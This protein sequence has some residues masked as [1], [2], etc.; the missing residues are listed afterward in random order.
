LPLIRFN[1]HAEIHKH[2]DDIPEPVVAF[3]RNAPHQSFQEEITKL[4]EGLIQ[5]NGDTPARNYFKWLFLGLCHY[6]LGRK[7]YVAY[8]E[9]AEEAAF[10]PAFL[11]LIVKLKYE[12]KRA[13]RI[14]VV[15]ALDEHLNRHIQKLER[16]HPHLK[17]VIAG[18]GF[19]ISDLL[20]TWNKY[21][22]VFLLGHGEDKSEGY[23]GH[24]TLGDQVMT[25]SMLKEHIRSNPLH[26]K[27]MGI[28]CCGMA[29][30]DP[31]IKSHF[32]FFIMDMESSV[33]IF[34]E[35]F[36]NGYLLEYYR[37][38]NVIDAFQHGRLATIFRA[39]SDPTYEIYMRGI[40]LQE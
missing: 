36:I 5:Y 14:L 37:S 3:Y 24:I 9:R 10:F 30:E 12:T 19:D 39:K 15:V 4:E 29:F 27:I 13:E 35:M 6:L 8:L 38:C 40:T 28:C 33:A 23:E 25:P 32:D 21:E 17:V 18:A 1:I 2:V 31:D 22:Q 26:P 20:R 16:L 7:S 11:P 34:V